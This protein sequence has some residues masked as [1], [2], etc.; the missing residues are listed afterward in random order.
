[1]IAGIFTSV[2]AGIGF[3]ISCFINEDLRRQKM[4]FTRAGRGLSVF[5]F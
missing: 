1:M 4:E 3:I 5:N 2:C